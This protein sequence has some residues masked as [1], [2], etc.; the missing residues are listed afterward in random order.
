[1]TQLFGLQHRRDVTF[2]SSGMKD[3]M[4]CKPNAMKRVSIAE[5][6]PTFIG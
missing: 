2:R 1:M 5:M 3:E 6:Q 4:S